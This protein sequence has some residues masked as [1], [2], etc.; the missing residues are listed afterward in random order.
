MVLLNI[1]ALQN[2]AFEYQRGNQKLKLE[3]EN[4][5]QVLKWDEKTELLLK[6]ENID[7][8]N[9]AISAP[10]LRRSEHRNNVNE[11]RW[12]IIPN[13]K[14]IQGDTL[15]LHISVRHSEDSIWT[16]KFKISIR[17]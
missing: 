6:F 7:L 4:G 14:Y 3:F 2:S 17:D 5:R 12:E 16:H 8:R 9:L 1:A 11:S 15:I 10:G 13:R